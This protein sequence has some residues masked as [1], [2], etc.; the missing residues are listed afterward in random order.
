MVTCA[1]DQEIGVISRRLLDNPGEF[2]N[3]FLK[4][5]FEIIF[6]V[7]YLFYL[8]AIGFLKKK[9]KQIITQLQSHSTPLEKQQL[10]WQPLLMNSQSGYSQE[11]LLSIVIWYIIIFIFPIR[12]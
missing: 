9:N 6:L 5:F 11:L 3:D 2:I 7:M 1:G 8:T 12:Y 4:T 10:S